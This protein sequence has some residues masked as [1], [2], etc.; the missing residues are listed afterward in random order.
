MAKRKQKT[1]YTVGFIALGCPKNIVDAEK[2]L[3]HIG[4]EGFIL[5]NDTDN[6][7]IIVVNTCGFIEP[8]KIEALD[9]IKDAVKLKKKGSV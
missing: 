6:A 3:A 7:D 1:T 9:A 4:S 5:T 2:M 8:A